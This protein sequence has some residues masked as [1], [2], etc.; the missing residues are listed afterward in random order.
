MDGLTLVD[1]IYVKYAG[2]REGEAPLTLGQLNVHDWIRDADRSYFGVVKLILNLP[3]G[4]TLDDITESFAILAA[5]HESLR[6]AFPPGDPLRQRV[7]GS[8]ELPIDIYAVDDGAL[9]GITGGSAGT[10][11]AYAPHEITPDAAAGIGWAPPS[12]GEKAADS[13]SLVARLRAVPLDTGDG[14]L[15]RVAVAVS[16]GRPRA[17]ALA[18]SHMIVDL[19]S[20]MVIG[21]QFTELASDPAK[22]Q[23]ILLGHQPLGHQPLD[24]AAAEDSAAGRRRADATLRF[25]EGQL[26]RMP[27]CMYAMPADPEQDGQPLSGW[28][29]SPAIRLALPAIMTRTGASP[30]MVVTAAMLAVLAHRTGNSGYAFRTISGNRSGLHLRDYVGTIAQVSLLAVDM[31][32]PGFDELVRRCGTATLRAARYGSFHQPSHLRMLRELGHLRGVCFHPDSVFNNLAA[33]DPGPGSGRPGVVGPDGAARAAQSRQTPIAWW[34]PPSSFN[35]TPLEFNLLRMPE[36]LAVG[37][38]TSDT[39]LVPPAEIE[40]LLHGIERLIAVAASGDVELSGLSEVTGVMPVDRGPGW[41]LIDSCWVQLAE[42][43]RLLDDALDVAVA[44]AFAVPGADGGPTLIACLAASAGTRTAGQ[45]HAVCVP[46]LDGRLTAMAPGRYLV[47]DQP[48]DDPD[49][50]ASWGE[51]R[52]LDDGDGRDPRI[53]ARYGMAAHPEGA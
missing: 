8:G 44:R 33:Y 26:R 47:Y 48:A 7:A 14:E 3:E 35:Q 37:L 18:C 32:A 13:Q 11:V 23:A 4:C 25:W 24:Q 15:V 53:A 43:Q 9:G 22:R 16:D 36:G 51:Q 42:V 1:R 10:G 5:R 40:S 46:A 52:L 29:S 20:I 17:A 6:T 38:W 50:L 21:R 49:S 28:L 34:R 39:T 31:P 2:E 45:A 27:Q 12:A 19:G 30:S 41:L